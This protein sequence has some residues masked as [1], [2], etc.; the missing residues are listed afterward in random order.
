MNPDLLI[1]DFRTYEFFWDFG[2]HEDVPFKI[3]FAITHFTFFL[4]FFCAFG[5]TRLPFCEIFLVRE[6]PI[7]VFC[8]GLGFS[9]FCDFV[10]HE[11]IPFVIFLAGIVSA[12]SPLF[13]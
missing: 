8:Y 12:V 11:D 6:R 1:I 5:G 3:F 10:G 7:L 2:G 9:F 4:Y 13:F